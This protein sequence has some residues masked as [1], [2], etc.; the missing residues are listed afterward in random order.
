MY[1][2]LT[3]VCD[4]CLILKEVSCSTQ[5]QICHDCMATI[6]KLRVCSMAWWTRCDLLTHQHFPC[7]GA[8][9]S[10]LRRS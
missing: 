5:G 10:A 2:L 7:W 4:I 9:T 6:A 1:K 3:T 8:T